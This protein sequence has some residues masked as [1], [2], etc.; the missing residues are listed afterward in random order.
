M[1]QNFPSNRSYISSKNLR[2]FLRDPTQPEALI[3]ILK[4]A[5]QRF[6]RVDFQL[7]L[8]NSKKIKKR[9]KLEQ[10]K[11]SRELLDSLFSK[12]L[13]I[14]VIQYLL[15]LF[16][17]TTT[18]SSNFIRIQS[19]KHSTFKHFSWRP[20]LLHSCKVV[21]RVNLSFL[22]SFKLRVHCSF[23]KYIKEDVNWQ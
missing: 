18:S 21:S 5:L 1:Q 9:S 3:L 23:I 8:L 7:V 16:F 11:K 22:P 15:S 12:W 2:N 14:R 4:L 19:C 17:F 6:F 20:P 13:F 10:M